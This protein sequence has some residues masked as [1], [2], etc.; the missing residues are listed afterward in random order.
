[1]SQVMQKPS[2]EEMEEILE[3]AADLNEEEIPPEKIQQSL[4]KKGLDEES[5]ARIVENLDTYT[6]DNRGRKK[7]ISG[8]LWCFGGIAVTLITHSMASGGGT[9]IIA[10]GAI[11]FGVIEFFRGLSYYKR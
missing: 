7:I 1:M 2:R 6:K 9:Y 8:A 5:A 3:Y 10:W 11:L 4:V